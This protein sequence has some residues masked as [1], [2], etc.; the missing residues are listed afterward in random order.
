MRRAALILTGV[1]VLV[2]NVTGC[3]GGGSHPRVDPRVMLRSA[4]A[5]PIESADTDIDLRLRVDGVPRL[6]GPLRLRLRGPYRSGG[7]QRIPSFDWRLSA[8]VLGFPVGG[9]LISTGDNV[10]LSV[11]GNQYEVGRSAISDANTRL[12]SAG[13]VR[14]RLGHW[15]GRARVTGEDDQ[16]GEDCERI[17]APLRG[18][19]VQSDL[20]PL[21]GALGFEPPSVSG[22]AIACVGYDDR[23]L[24][25][26]QVDAVLGL[27]PADS[28]RLAGATHVHVEADIVSSDVGKPQQ[29]EAPSGPFRPIRDLFL[30]LNDLAGSL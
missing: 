24:H 26:L 22:R 7:R 27:P 8:G 16:G 20:V 9:R 6:S 5:H 19:A 23:V 11:Y 21:A 15:L 30:T 12:A 25:E 14:L 10:Y 17:A 1:L 18:G 13:G 3:G 28:A 29:I 2:V 4:E